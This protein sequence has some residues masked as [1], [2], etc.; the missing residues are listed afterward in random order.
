MQKLNRRTSMNQ[1]HFSLKLTKMHYRAT[2]NNQTF[3]EQWSDLEE[4]NTKQSFASQCIE[5]PRNGI[6][7]DNN[8]KK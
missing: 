6:D 8:C 2:R 4:L 7:G 3:R 1:F 5:L